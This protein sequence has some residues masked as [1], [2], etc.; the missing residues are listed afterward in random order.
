VVTRG[1]IGTANVLGIHQSYMER[2]SSLSSV[3]RV[4]K[5]TPKAK[6][7]VDLII[8][9]RVSSAAASLPPCRSSI[10]GIRVA[11]AVVIVVS[12]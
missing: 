10:L 2:G 6:Q 5:T 9:V 4:G 7:K 8:T 3:V 11:V 12:A 1:N